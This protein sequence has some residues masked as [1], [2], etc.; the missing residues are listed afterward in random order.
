MNQIQQ[1][2]EQDVLEADYFTYFQDY[3]PS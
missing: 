3:D 1:L 2:P